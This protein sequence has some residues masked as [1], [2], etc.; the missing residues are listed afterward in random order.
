MINNVIGKNV[1]YAEV[2]FRVIASN[3]TDNH[4]GI[5]WIDGNDK[6]Y[7]AFLRPNS[8]TLARKD[9]GQIVRTLADR[10]IGE[11]YTLKVLYTNNSISVFLN[12]MPKPTITIPHVPHDTY[13]SKVGIR[14][15]NTVTEF[16]PIMISKV[17]IPTPTQFHD[18]VKGRTIQYDLLD[19]ED[20][21]SQV[22]TR[23][24]YTL[25]IVYNSK[26]MNIFLN[27]N[28]KF[29]V[30]ITSLADIWRVGIRSH[31]NIAKFEPLKIGTTSIHGFQYAY[32][33]PITSKVLEYNNGNYLLH[34]KSQLSG[35]KT[36][37]LKGV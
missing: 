2:T 4:A 5:V 15:F 20:Q 29:Q 34:N 16:K 23:V 27:N 25:K 21:Q 22:N 33:I 13:I 10:H 6:E 19:F 31:N 8:L 36:L 35:S 17:S 1:N 9:M 24:W 32:Y 11:W 18:Q 26:S 28:L 3:R 30:P 14:T 37:T 7:Y 12:D